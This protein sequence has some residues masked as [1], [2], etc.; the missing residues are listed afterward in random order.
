MTLTYEP[1]TLNLHTP[2]RIAHGVSEQR[3]N[4]VVH[5]NGGLGEAAAVAYHGETQQKIMDYL[6]AVA[7][8]VGDDPFALE[9]T[10]NSLPVG[11]QAARAAIDLALHDRWGKALGQ[12]LF[13]LLGLK[14]DRL[15]LTSFTIAMDEPAVMAERAKASGMPIIKI[16]LG[17]ADDEAMV[18]AIRSATA[19][20][21]RVDANAGWTR[22]QAADLIPRLAQY[23]LEF[24]EQ[25]LPVGDIEGLRWLRARLRSLKLGVP[26]FADEPV[27]T[28]KDVVA[29]AGA[30]DGVVI[31]LMKTGGL[32]EA[33]RAIAVARA[34][35]LQIMIG[36]M[37]E[38]SIGVT[39]AAHLASLCDYAD[40]DGPLLIA[41]DPYRGVRYDGARLILPDAPGL[42]VR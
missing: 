13:R 33:M 7:D 31:K 34:H 38:S 26:I 9:D 23:D 42:G 22:E 20:K 8:R 32:R 3:H 27:K 21:L 37:V 11:S 29:H 6:A 40:L 10:L 24:V 14:P 28:A 4:V 15:P 39:A 25:P 30:I 16:K 19:A 36:C 1:L 41:N 17:G 35:D 2:F 12:P 18:R 5:I